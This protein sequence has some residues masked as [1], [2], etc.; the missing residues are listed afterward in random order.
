MEGVMA[1]FDLESTYLGVEANRIT[2]VPGGP[3]FWKTVGRNPAAGG[4]LVTASA[5]TA[6]S[7]HWEMHPEGDEALVLLEGEVRMIFEAPSGAEAHDMAPGSTL[8]VPQGTW[9][10]AE[11]QSAYRMLYMTFGSGTRHKPL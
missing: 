3:E 8:V 1:T 9:H 4:M 5:G 11:T 6:N 7:R 2:P 10:R